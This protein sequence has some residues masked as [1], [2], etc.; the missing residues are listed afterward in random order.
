MMQNPYT[1]PYENHTPSMEMI[2]NP[3]TQTYEKHSKSIGIVRTIT[4][5]DESFMKTIVLLSSKPY[6]LYHLYVYN[7]AQDHTFG[8][9]AIDNKVRPLPVINTSAIDKEDC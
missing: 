9:R 2:Q 5:S 7:I 3:Y 6:L 1:Y 4:K 8:N